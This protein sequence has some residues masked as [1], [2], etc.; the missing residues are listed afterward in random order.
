MSVFWYYWLGD[1]MGYFLK[2]WVIFSNLLI[3]L[4]SF[5]QKCQGMMNKLLNHKQCD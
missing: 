2:D 4:V 5:Q 3:T 1:F